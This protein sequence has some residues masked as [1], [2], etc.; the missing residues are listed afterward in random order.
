MSAGNGKKKTGNLKGYKCFT[1][2]SNSGGTYTTCKD[3]AQQLRIASAKKRPELTKPKQK[4]FIVKPKPKT[5]QSAKAK[6]PIKPKRPRGRPKTLPTKVKQPPKKLGRKLGG[7]NKPKPTGEDEEGNV[8][9]SQLRLTENLNG[10]KFK[11][12]DD[13]YRNEIYIN[14]ANGDI[15]DPDTGKKVG[16]K[17][18]TL[19]GVK[20]PKEG[21]YKITAKKWLT[22]HMPNKDPNN[23]ILINIFKGKVLK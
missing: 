12:D 20:V 7:K 13:S 14:D 9:V 22:R 15:L 21:Y 16:R 6:V 5:T 19:K 3:D 4:K 10:I 23:N 2:T 1:R 18:N 17:I 8:E 11:Y